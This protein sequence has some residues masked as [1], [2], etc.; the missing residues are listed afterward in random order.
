[1]P[2]WY[3]YLCVTSHMFV[4]AGKYLQSNKNGNAK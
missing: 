4:V 3:A 2:I 1:M